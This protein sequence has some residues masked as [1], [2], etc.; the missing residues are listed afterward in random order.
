M[1]RILPLRLTSLIN[2]LQRLAAHRDNITV[3][4]I[5]RYKLHDFAS[6]VI[7]LSKC[8]PVQ[9]GFFLFFSACIET[10]PALTQSGKIFLLALRSVTASLRWYLTEIKKSRDEAHVVLEQNVAWR[11]LVSSFRNVPSRSDRY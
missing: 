4:N 6:Y 1:A 2:S 7:Q 5:R 3:P 8:R 11:F 9:Q 10:R